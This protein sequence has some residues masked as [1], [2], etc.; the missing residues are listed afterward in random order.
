MAKG[1]KYAVQP[2][3]YGKEDLAR[4]VEEE[5]RRIESSIDWLWH[6]TRNILSVSTTTV[7]NSGTTE[8]DLFSFSVPENT[9]RKDRESLEFWFGGTLLSHATATRQL[10]VKFGAT[11][12][13][14]STAQTNTTN[15]EFSIR[16]QIIRVN[17][18]SQKSIVFL[19]TTQAQLFVFA[20]YTT[21]AETLSS[22][23]IL[24][25]T[26]QAGGVG[27]ATNDIKFELGKV[28]WFPKD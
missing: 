22:A 7:G 13:F 11:T 26:G 2:S 15:Y 1:L 4:Y 17:A 24:K 23:S 20:D 25:L 21:S 14:D 16:G 19:N 18:T 27:A 10:R 28:S 6:D 8:T 3:P 12:I 5:L 9:L